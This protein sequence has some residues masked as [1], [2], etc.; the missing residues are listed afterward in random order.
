[1]HETIDLVYDFRGAYS[2]KELAAKQ[3][4]VC[5]RQLRVR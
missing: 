2:N 3:M 5:L 4:D 1:M